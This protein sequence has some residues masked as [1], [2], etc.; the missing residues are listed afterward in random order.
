MRLGLKIS[1][2]ANDPMV[3][4]PAT[5][6]VRFRNFRRSV[7]FLEISVSSG[8]LV[9]TYNLERTVFLGI[10]AVHH[11]KKALSILIKRVDNSY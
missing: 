4:T 1:Y 3:A 6:A 10:E 7:S 5:T 8:I 11:D 2:K 9:I